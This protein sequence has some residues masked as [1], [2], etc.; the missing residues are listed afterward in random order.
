MENDEIIIAVRFWQDS[1]RI[2]PLT[3][4]IDSKH[5]KLDAI[6]KDGVV[7]LDCPTCKEIQTIWP[8]DLIIRFYNDVYPKEDYME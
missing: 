1:G 4:G 2:H 3:C 8:K 5:D 7:V 6:V